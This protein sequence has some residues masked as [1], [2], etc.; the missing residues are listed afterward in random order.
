MLKILE[1]FVNIFFKVVYVMR[2]DDVL[3]IVN[4]I[5]MMVGI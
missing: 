3:V 5:L 2:V 4:D 1:I